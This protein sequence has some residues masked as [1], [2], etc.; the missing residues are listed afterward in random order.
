[1]NRFNVGNIT[2]NALQTLG[3]SATA[4]SAKFAGDKSKEDASSTLN[5]TTSKGSSQIKGKQS[6]IEQ[7]T[8]NVS[9]QQQNNGH[10]TTLVQNR[11]TGEWEEYGG[12][13][14][15]A[16]LSSPQIENIEQK[17]LND[18]KWLDYYTGKGVDK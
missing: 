12:E 4:A 15:P 14:Y 9:G 7:E 6:K 1:M 16:G 17:M 18:I 5:N 3:I 2:T 8:E 13:L 10:V 11:E